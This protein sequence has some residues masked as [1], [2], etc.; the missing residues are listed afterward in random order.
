MQHTAAFHQGLHC[1]HRMKQPLE[2]EI[3]YNLEMSTCD[4]FKYEM[5]KPILIVSICMGKS[6]RKGLLALK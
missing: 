6:T 2:T 1:M 5:G 4:P 3:H